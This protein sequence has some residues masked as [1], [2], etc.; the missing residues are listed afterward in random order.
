MLY[1]NTFRY[2]TAEQKVTV[3]K[4]MT[5]DA[6]LKKVL[7]KH[8]HFVCRRLKTFGQL[9][10]Y[11]DE[12]YNFDIGWTIK[13]GSK[14]ITVISIKCRTTISST[15]DPPFPMQDAP[16]TSLGQWGMQGLTLKCILS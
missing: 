14:K 11:N 7:I 16:Q 2:S 3:F 8:L 6:L 5:N 9:L 4:Y 15:S 12:E 10:L 13:Q 1:E